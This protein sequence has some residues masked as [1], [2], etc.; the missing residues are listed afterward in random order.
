M[1]RFAI[2]CIAGLCVA[3][4]S[5]ALT[6][7][8]Q[9]AILASIKCTQ[10]IAT[11]VDNLPFYQDCRGPSE[12]MLDGNPAEVA[13]IIARFADDPSNPRLDSLVYRGKSNDASGS[14][15]GLNGPFSED[16]AGNTSGLLKFDDLL[17][18]VF[19]VGL[20]G[21]FASVPGDPSIPNYSYYLFDSDPL[22]TGTLGIGTLNFDTDGIVRSDNLS[23]GGP[24]AFAALYTLGSPAGGTVPEPTGIALAAVAFGAL[25]LTTRRRRG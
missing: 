18:G 1:K 4:G 10:S 19:V 14:P 2:R 24:L 3:A 7:P 13:K 23:R 17:R 22:R 9:A 6:L 5:L 15:F 12:G 25:A 16:P 8:A 20:Q 11:T 21:G